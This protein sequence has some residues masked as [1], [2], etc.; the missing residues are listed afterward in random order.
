MSYLKESVNWLKQKIIESKGLGTAKGKLIDYRE[1]HRIQYGI[2]LGLTIFRPKKLIEK[3][4]ANKTKFL[5]WEA[6]EL[7]YQDQAMVYTYI[8][9]IIILSIIAPGAV[10]YAILGA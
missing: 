1:A 9:K 6:Q 3:S 2:I 8:L 5:E 4:K 7:Q 10:N